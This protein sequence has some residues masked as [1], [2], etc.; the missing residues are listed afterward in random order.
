MGECISTRP[1]IEK[2]TSHPWFTVAS[3]TCEAYTMDIWPRQGDENGIQQYPSRGVSQVEAKQSERTVLICKNT[4]SSN[5]LRPAMQS[6]RQFVQLHDLF[7]E[8]V[9]LLILLGI[10]LEN[11]ARHRVCSNRWW[12]ACLPDIGSL[13]GFVSSV[14]SSMHD[15]QLLVNVLHAF[16]S[17]AHRR[18]RRPLRIFC[19]HHVRI[20]VLVVKRPPTATS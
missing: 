17:R 12:L 2:K 10:L 3:Y 11:I 5:M 7:S 15:D 4:T 8:I 18:K 1:I 14:S 13:D 16:I 6:T 20:E 9:F 19:S